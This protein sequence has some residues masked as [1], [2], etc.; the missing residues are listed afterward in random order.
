MASRS[1]I[2][3]PVPPGQAIALALPGSPRGSAGVGLCKLEC[4]PTKEVSTSYVNQTVLY[5]P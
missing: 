1:P 2:T 3:L 4:Q 5:S